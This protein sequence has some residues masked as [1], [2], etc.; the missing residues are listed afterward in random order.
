MNAENALVARGMHALYCIAL[1]M[2]SLVIIRQVFS[3]H[4]SCMISFVRFVPRKRLIAIASVI[5]SAQGAPVTRQK[6]PYIVL[7]SPG[8]C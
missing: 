1:I 4:K 5:R 2:N 8:I 7:I 3:H 6:T